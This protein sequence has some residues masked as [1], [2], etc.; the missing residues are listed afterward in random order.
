ML[1]TEMVFQV[2]YCD[3]GECRII[4]IIRFR[5]SIFVNQF[6]KNMVK[7]QRHPSD[8]MQTWS[9]VSTQDRNL[10]HY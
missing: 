10:H 7:N 6:Y 8:R 3:E 1:Q 5:E 2:Q 9:R 4:N